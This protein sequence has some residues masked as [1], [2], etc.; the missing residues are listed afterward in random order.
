[1]NH[2]ERVRLFG[3][4]RSSIERD[5]DRIERDLKIDLQRGGDDSDSDEDYYLQF[6]H[7]LRVEA[8]AMGRH[9]A[10]FYCLEQSIRKLIT[11]TLRAERGEKWWEACVP[12]PVKTAVALN[13]KRELEF[14]VTPRSDEEIDYTTFGELAEIARAN[15][16][17]FGGIFTSEKG[18]NR[19]MTI[20]N[21]L[22][23]P[24]A[25]C[26]PLAENEVVRLRLTLR[27]WFR[28]ME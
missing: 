13:I 15:W 17:S 27:D 10:L 26:S 3:V 11:D 9:Y 12:E 16:E 24:I 22:R 1:V 19:I 5:L 14:A 8:E 18:F 28:L 25:H 21:I 20:L 7:R 2:L 4:S 23:G 6:E